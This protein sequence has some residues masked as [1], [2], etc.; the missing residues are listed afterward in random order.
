M[1][2]I[3]AEL[4]LQCDNDLGEGLFS[5]SRLIVCGG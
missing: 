2:Q 3:K 4:V 1:L 5:T